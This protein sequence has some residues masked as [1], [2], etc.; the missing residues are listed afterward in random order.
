MGAKPVI[1]SVFGQSCTI[2]YAVPFDPRREGV[3]D[4][5]TLVLPI[6]TAEIVED[7]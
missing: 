6:V 1:I 2:E 3:P 7:R 4:Q 5:D